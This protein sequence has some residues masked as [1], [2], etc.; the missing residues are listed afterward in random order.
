MLLYLSHQ[1]RGHLLA[2]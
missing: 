2:F 1:R